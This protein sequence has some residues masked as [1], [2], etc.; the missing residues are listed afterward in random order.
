MEN[1]IDTI[2]TSCKDC[3]FALYDKKTQAGC[4]LKYIDHY[5]SSDI[6]VIEAYDKDTEFFIINGK[7]CIGYRENSWFAQYGL[8]N[9]SIEQKAD[10]FHE[11][12]R[13]DYV[14]VINFI[15][16]GSTETDIINIQKSLSS[17]K[18][19]PAKIVFVRSP[20]GLETTIYASIQKLMTKVK[21]DCKW[22]IQT[23][24]DESVS[25]EN[26][27]HGI[28]NQDKSYRFV[29]HMKKSDCSGL[30]GLV[31]KAN[32]IVYTKLGRFIVLTDQ[33]HSCV[34]FGASVYRFSLAEN[35]KDI[36]SDSSNFTIV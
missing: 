24:V 8:E 33:D 28:I 6:D 31:D 14:L 15:E 13:I 1:K 7:K 19:P 9:A 18:I 36:L 20:E 5:K 21:L 17:L 26:I 23:M 2:H 16:I 25:N 10:K 27:L 34:L 3:V 11:L 4:F 32:D 12:N 30:G 35:G 29:C 22:R